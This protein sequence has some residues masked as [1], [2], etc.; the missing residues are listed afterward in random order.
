MNKKLKNNLSWGTTVFATVCGVVAFFLI[1]ARA[2]NYTG[3]IFGSSFTGL[4]VALGYTV[5]DVPVFKASAG[6][7]L[8]YLFPLIGACV[9]LIGKG[10]KIVTFL[11][12]GL[13]LTGGVLLF[14]MTSLL[15]G[16]AVGAPSLAAGPIAAG[17]VAILG[18]VTE[19]AG[20]FLS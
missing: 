10:N 5:N 11:A 7:I 13:L 20:T 4:Q 6:I 17:V 1:F 8:G 18:G 9:A 12:S 2:V 15:N 19:C 3:L 14:C 16:S